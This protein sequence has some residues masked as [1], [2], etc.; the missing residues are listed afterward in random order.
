LEKARRKLEEKNEKDFQ[1]LNQE[2]ELLIHEAHKLTNKETGRDIEV[3]KLKN[4]LSSTNLSSKRCLEENAQQK[5][6]EDIL[7]DILDRR[8]AKKETELQCPIC[9]EISTPPIF[10][11]P[12][13]HLVCAHCKL[14]ISRCSEC[15]IPFEEPPKRHRYAEKIAEEI[16]ELRKER[17]AM[18]ENMSHH[19][20]I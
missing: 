16:K 8:I 10:T 2:E 18:I 7:L 12:D 1:S 15:N 6:R 20:N 17:E 4:Q 14:R 9:Y 11:C 19:S 5:S 13:S 3:D